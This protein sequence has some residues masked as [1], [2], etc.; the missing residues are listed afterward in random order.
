RPDPRWTLT[1]S[2]QNL[3]DVDT[4]TNATRRASVNQAGGSLTLSENRF[5]AM[6]FDARR[7]GGRDLGL[8]GSF[9]RRLGDRGDR[10]L[11]YF[12]DRS[13][14]DRTETAS[15]RVQEN[16]HPR[17]GLLQVVNWSN[18]SW[19]FNAGGQFLSNPISI[20]IGYQTVYAPFRTAGPFVRTVTVDAR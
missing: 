18:G 9:G 5:S 17:V 4:L 2:R 3:L 6:V 16:V 10:G 1:A 19:S 11:E 7:D 14:T 15:G 20:D 8:S 13:A 12:R